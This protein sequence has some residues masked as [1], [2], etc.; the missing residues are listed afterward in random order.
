MIAAFIKSLKLVDIDK[1]SDAAKSSPAEPRNRSEFV[2]I[3]LEE[4]RLKCPGVTERQVLRWA[5]GFVGIERY[6]DK[7]YSW[8]RKDAIDLADEFYQD[9]WG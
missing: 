1:R 9:L 8:T 6:G 2:A 5:G 3:M 4:L 7:A